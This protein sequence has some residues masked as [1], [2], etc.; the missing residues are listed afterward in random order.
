MR[1]ANGSIPRDLAMWSMIVS[2]TSIPCRKKEKKKKDKDKGKPQGSTVPLF[3]FPTGVTSH[4]DTVHYD[5]S[6][7]QGWLSLALFIR[8]S[9]NFWNQVSSPIK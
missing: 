5:K 1:S 9:P 2:V 3:R 7:V 4:V 8:T 6:F